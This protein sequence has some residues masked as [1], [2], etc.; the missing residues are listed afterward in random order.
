LLGGEI[1]NQSNAINPANVAV[2]IGATGTLG[3]WPD[4]NHNLGNVTISGGT[5]SGSATGNG[6][7]FTFVGG[8][9]VLVNGTSTSNVTSQRGIRLT[10]AGGTVNFNVGNG[11]SLGTGNPDLVVAAPISGA[12][13]LNK[14]GP[15][16]MR[17]SAQGTY[18][19]GTTINAGTLQLAIPGSTGT[20]TVT[21]S[22][23][24]SGNGTV[25]G[26]LNTLNGGTVLPNDPATNGPGRLTQ[27]AGNSDFASGSTLAARIGGDTD[28]DASRS[29]ISTTGTLTF[30]N[31]GAG[32]WTVDVSKVATY[33]PTATPHTYTLAQAGAIP[34]T[35]LNTPISLTAA[36]SGQQIA[37]NGTTTLRVSGFAAGDS[38]TLSRQGNLIVLNYN[39]VP[40]PV[41]VLTIFGAGLAFAA[42]RRPRSAAI[43]LSTLPGRGSA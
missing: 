30:P 34:S 22:G 29:Q 10:A 37:S 11:A 19:G 3:S 14:T 31:S 16:I 7:N 18:A 32:T 42:W 17:L 12:G 15:G 26:Q 5:I 20:G 24:L 36:G 38:F 27:T 4:T 21:N 6:P 9:T 1:N 43:D 40:E 33:T 39:P 41:A 23:T 13:A 35:G 8:S 25:G 2:A 28:I